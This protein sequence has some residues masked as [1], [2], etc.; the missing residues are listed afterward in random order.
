MPLTYSLLRP[1]SNPLARAPKISTAFKPEHVVTIE[2]Q[3]IASR[4]KP[5]RLGPILVALLGW[6]AIGYMAYLIANSTIKTTKLYDPYEIL[7]ISQSATEKEIKSAFKRMSLKFH[8][9]KIRID[10]AKNESAE[11]VNA[12]Y[13]DLNK[14][15][16]ALT[17]EEIRNNWINFGNPDGKQSFSYGIGLPSFLVNNKIATRAVIIIYCVMFFNVLPYVVGSWWYGVQ[18]VSKDGVLMESANNMFG[19]YKE[20]IDEGGVITALSIAKEF[21]CHVKGKDKSHLSKVESKILAEGDVG[22]VAGGLS[23]KDKASLQDMNST[24]RRKALG[25]LWAYLSRTDLDDATLNALKYKVAPIAHDVAK[26]FL[27]ISLAYG[28]TAPILATFR[29]AQHLVQAI[30]PM[31]SP[32]LQLPHFTPKVVRA[33][34]GDSRIHYTIQR[35]MDLPD[36]ERR[37]LA[38]GPGLLTEE[39]YGTALEISRQLPYFRVAK[40]FFKVAGERFIIPSSLVSLVVKGRFVPPGTENVPEVNE[41]DLE[42]IDPAEDDLDAILGRKKKKGK[43][44]DGKDAGGDDA[45]ALPPM[46]FAPYYTRNHSPKWSVFLTDSKQGKMAVPPFSFSAFDTQIATPDGKPSLS[47]QTMKAQFQAPPQP[48]NYTFVMHVICDGYVGFDTKMEVTMHVEPASKVAQMKVEDDISEPE[49]GKIYSCP[50]PIRTL[51]YIALNR[52]ADPDIFYLFRLS[53]RPDAGS[54]ARRHEKGEV[55]ELGIRR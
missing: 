11:S 38:V 4:R 15:Y 33:V 7:G 29:A 6:A 19:E 55:F 46:S 53:C 54:Q 45:P 48:G 39:E 9:D 2:K 14:A 30:P 31:A 22:P 51:Q 28:N 5:L 41:T 10:P 23:T 18:R 12:R 25:L 3:R 40:A 44:A 50:V 37:R 24:N 42:D 17:D 49:R 36:A 27:S 34:E 43:K 20:D 1:S 13:V 35:F 26:S 32:L 21:E 8:P 16:Q 52:K 47:M